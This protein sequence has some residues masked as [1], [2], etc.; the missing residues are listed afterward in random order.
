MASAT[1][2]AI[3]WK[4]QVSALVK[5]LAGKIV[6][7][8][9]YNQTNYQTKQVD[10][11]R[12]ILRFVIN[13]CQL[14][15]P[16]TRAITE[17]CCCIANI[18]NNRQLSGLRPWDSGSR[19]CWML[20]LTVFCIPSSQSDRL[21]A[22][23]ITLALHIHTTHVYHSL[24]RQQ[25]ATLLSRLVHSMRTPSTVCTRTIKWLQKMYTVCCSIQNA[26]IW[27]TD[28]CFH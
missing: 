23:S 5:W 14:F 22:G 24:F 21:S 19:H 27:S 17:S 8:V 4:D 18:E 9:T 6:S 3:G 26:L 25:T 10:T 2:Q 1:S 12:T 11:V 13:F 28:F 16:V 7:K 15:G 20:C